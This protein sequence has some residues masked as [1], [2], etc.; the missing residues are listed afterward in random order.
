[1][2]IA[3]LGLHFIVPLCSHL[4]TTWSN[5]Q[6]KPLFIF[7][8]S[9]PRYSQSMINTHRHTHR[10]THTHTNTH[11]HTH[12]RTHTSFIST[13]LIHNSYINYIKLNASTCFERHPPILRWSMS[14]IVHVC[15]L[16]Y[17]HSLQVA[18][19]CTC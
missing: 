9:I 1:M 7:G 3:F 8:N 14:L 5:A 15:N 17:S 12:K 13:N 6:E 19:L 4:R 10:H 11:K 18:V 16:W 2:F